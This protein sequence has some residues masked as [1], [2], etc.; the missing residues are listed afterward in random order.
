MQSYLKESA[1]S[2]VGDEARP[3]T[4]KVVVLYGL[5]GI[6]KSS[7]VLEYS[8]QYSKSYTAIFWVDVTSEISLARSVRGIAEY[9]VA[10]YAARGVSY[11]NIASTLG[12]RG[13][14]NSSGQIASDEAAEY[15]VIE[16]FRDWLAADHNEQWLLV[17]DNYD[18]VDTV[19]ID[20]ILPT[21]DNRTVIITSRKSNLHALGK[22]VSVDE[23]NK[24][25]GITLLLRSAN[26]AEDGAEGK[27]QSKPFRIID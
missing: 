22:T 10:F 12:L 25:S 2:K 14:L 3:L 16:A 15:R 21:C 4:R 20:R 27:H 6:G 5:G 1:A 13:L 17:L 11:E 7:I 26:K 9:L 8:F 23:I 18:D 24:Q 19:D